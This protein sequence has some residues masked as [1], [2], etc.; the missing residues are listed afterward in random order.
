MTKGV[1]IFAMNGSFNYQE[2]ALRSAKRIKHHLNLP[3][4]IVTNQE[5]LDEL[6]NL[7]DHI[8]MQEDNRLNY[9]KMQDG[10]N[11]SEKHIWK[12]STRSSAYDITPYDETLVVDADYIVNS[13]FLLNCFNLDKDFLLFKKSYDLAGW[14]STT[15]FQAINSYSVSFYWATVFYFR[16]TEQNKIFF[17]LISYIKDNWSYYRLLYQIA[18]KKYRNDFAFSIALHILNGYTA[19]TVDVIPNKMYYTLDRDILID[20]TDNSCTFL[21]EKKGNPAEY[22]ACKATNID[23]HVMNK[24]SILRVL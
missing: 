8:I 6:S 24:H 12:N 10:N 3:I 22:T 11:G 9:R 4:S 2:L 1:L 13:N 23:V 7:A 21:V 14:R 20:A 16:K 19:D 18:D 5:P 17:E 15:E